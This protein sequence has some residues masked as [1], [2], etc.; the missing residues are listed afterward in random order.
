MRAVPQRASGLLVVLA[1]T[2]TTL[3]VAL[4]I[5]APC[6]GSWA[7]GR[8][9]V[10]LCYSD[11]AALYGSGDRD[12]GLEERRVP[13]IDAQNEYPVLTGLVMWVAALPAST[14]PQFFAWTSVLLAG[15]AFATASALHRMAGRR[16]LV[17]AAAPTLAIYAFVN[18]DLIAVALATGATLLHLRDRDRGAG[19][20][21]GLGA[22]AKLYPA[23]LV[24]PFAIGRLQEHRRDD[25]RALVL[26]AGGTWLA[27]NLP[28]ALLGFERWSEFFRFNSQRPADWDSL[29]LMLAR[30]HEVLG[31]RYEGFTWNIP[32]LNMLTG[33]AFVALAA[34]LW[35]AKR[36]RHPGFPAWTFGF[37]L[38]V[39]FLLTGKVYSP[40][41]GL[42]LLPWFALA[43]PDPRLFVA[44][45]IADAAVFFTRFRFFAGFE[46]L[47]D[48][49]PFGAFEV[50][51]L[52][53]AAV[54]VVCLVAWVRR[55]VP[56]TEPRPEMVAA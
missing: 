31:L 49:V 35:F 1:L 52:V 42:W 21:L 28:F 44:F 16:A 29:W 33:L 19:L 53:R 17:F 10:R 11:V 50:A 37:P 18:W 40:Q 43:L 15:A 45:G 56:R 2:G 34:W 36:R 12:R 39:A 48:G 22:A 9:Y 55:P 32:F 20:L 24:I 41:Y 26:W 27:V 8:Q 30:P 23:L 25:A 14:Y 46:G 13:Y 4:A 38:I 51:I 47:G 3:A 54:L 5:R 7:D 6:Q